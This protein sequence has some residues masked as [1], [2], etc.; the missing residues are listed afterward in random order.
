[1]LTLLDTFAGIGG[2]TYAAE[3]LVGG[4]QTTAFVENN[5][6]CCEKL[7]ENYPG[8]AVYETSITE[9]TGATGQWDVITGGFP[10][11]DLS[12][13]GKGLGF[14]GT[15]SVL[16]YELVRLLGEIRPKYAIFENVDRLRTH[17][18]GETFQKVLYEIAKAGYNAEWAIIRAKDVG[19]CHRR[20]RI[21]I[22]AYAHDERLERRLLQKL[23]E[24][25]EQFASWPR[26][27]QICE[28]DFRR[29]NSEPT[30]RR[31][32]DGLSGRVDRHRQLGNA[33]V[34]HVAAVPL[35]RIKQLE[36]LKR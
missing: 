31:R 2:F 33:V 4:F 11:Q 12:C 16:F 9:F 15:R 5:T 22:I 13:A 1:M 18:D 25:P 35:A 20:P 3:K 26:N 28:G 10:C 27:I 17:Q 24:C 14:S 7:R 19:A 6:K 30:V 8:I 29:F 32:D 23:Q 34:P 21:F 36:E